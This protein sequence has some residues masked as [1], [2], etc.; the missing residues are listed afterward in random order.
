MSSSFRSLEVKMQRREKNTFRTTCH[1]LCLL[2]KIKVEPVVPAPSPVI[3]R[4]TLRVGAGQ[5]KIV[6]SKVVSAPEAKPAPSLN[7][8]KT[9]P[10]TPAAVPVHMNPTPL[11]L[12]LLPQATACP[13]LMPSLAPALVAAGSSKAPVRS[14]VT[15]T[16]ST[17]VIRDE[18]GNQIWICPGCNKP[19]D[20]SPMIG[21]DDCD[22]WYHW[23]CVGIMAAPPEE[24]Q[25]FCPKCANKKKDK[26][27]KKRK[28]R[29]H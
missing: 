23:P 25:W 8:P 24:M 15:E 4:L 14:V 13:V 5:D 3:P 21:C 28:H 6:I 26:K 2:K 1:P 7:R 10:P 27:H 16:V 12:P 11:P 18:S 9:P 29:A 20:G 19:D 17:Y 22:D